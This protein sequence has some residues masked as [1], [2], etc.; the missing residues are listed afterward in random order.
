MHRLGRVV[1][2]ALLIAACAAPAPPEP[3]A[4]ATASPEPTPVVFGITPEL[5][6]EGQPYPLRDDRVNGDETLV[7]RLGFYTAMDLGSVSTAIRRHLPEATAFR[8]APPAADVLF[9]VPPGTGTLVIDPTGA[10]SASGGGTVVP[11]S[12]RITRPETIVSLYDPARVGDATTPVHTMRFRVAPNG[13]PVRFDPAMRTVLLSHTPA[14][15][16][17]VDVET[18]RR[19][20]LPDRL[21][22]IYSSGS[23][24]FGWLPDGR[25]LAVGSSETFIGD[26]RGLQLRPLPALLGQSGVVSPSGR[27]LALWSYAKGAAAI[28]DLDAGTSLPLGGEFPRCSVGGG[29]GLTWAPDSRT[30]AISDCAADMAGASRTRFFDASSGQLLRTAEGISVIAW[31]GDGRMLLTRWSPTETDPR[32]LPESPAE[33]VDARG[34]ILGRIGIRGAL[35]ISPDGRWLLDT[36]EDPQHPRLRV[37]EIATGRAQLL[38]VTETTATWTPSGMIAVAASPAP[39]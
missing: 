17:F 12:W 20:P 30:I 1:G 10:R 33:I 26:E 39:R 29:V 34:T 3:S 15:A 32:R 9:E 6:L 2:A 18:A 13:G 22:S 35:G 7:F 24:Y 19:T 25:F 27:L 11:K 28:V 23:T 36:G 37:V 38:P 5:F 16:S 14:N 4:T 21:A 8:A 31:F